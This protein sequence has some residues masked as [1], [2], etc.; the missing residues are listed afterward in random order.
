MSGT[1]EPRDALEG[2]AKLARRSASYAVDDATKRASRAALLDRVENE[3]SRRSFRSSLRVLV[4]GLAAAAAIALFF[5]WPRTL[6]YDVDG[7]RSENGYVSAPSQRAV[8]LRFSDETEVLAESGARLRVENTSARGARVLVE[9][10]RARVQVSHREGAE[11]TFVAGPFE[12][13]V[14]GTRFVMSWEPAHEAFEL[15]LEQGAVNVRGPFGTGPIALSAGQRFRG[16][17]A[18]RSMSVTNGLAVLEKTPA[19]APVELPAPAQMPPLAPPA[20]SA[21]AAPASRDPLPSPHRTQRPWTQRIV[22]GEFETIVQEAEARGIAATLASAS[23][24]D[25]RA[26]SDAARYVGRPDLAEQSLLSLRRRFAGGADGRAAAFMLGRLQEGRGRS[27]QAKSFYETYLSESPSGNFAAEALA[28]KM[29]TVLALSGRAAAQ[30]IARDYLAR[31]P[32][33]VHAKTARGI[34]GTQ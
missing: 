28:G 1:P 14:R 24:T 23:S 33:G 18:T 7:A 29:R 2:I 21:E 6:S 19:V 11:W 15:M 16:D 22:D 27:A 5:A 20:E 17:G 30:P 12:V 9:R 31:Y 26:L 3:P 25:L 34:V 10:G 13:E 8:T 4:P 32:T